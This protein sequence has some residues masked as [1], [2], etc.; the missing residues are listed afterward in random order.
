MFNQLWKYDLMT[1]LLSWVAGYIDTSVFF[2]L[3]GL[4]T[5][6][7]T[8]N[9]VVAGAELGNLGQIDV[10]VLVR[11]AVVPVF[12]SAIALVTV[13]TRWREVPLSHLLGLEAVFLLLFAIVGVANTHLIYPK[14]L[15]YGVFT[16]GSVGVFAMGIQNA[17]MREKLKGAAQTTIMTGNLTQLT[18]D[19]VQ[20]FLFY[21]TLE[22]REEVEQR[23]RQMSSA[24]LSFIVGAA[25]GAY[26]M[27]AI[28]FW[29]IVIAAAVIIFLALLQRLSRS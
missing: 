23:V 10:W 9:L 27:K 25:C 28:G 22:K 29:S 16:T 2:G 13:I 17:L 8:G 21:Q 6:H 15:P 3:N 24:L 7:V 26:F 1:I 18:I 12:I 20:T 5:A 19:L 4:F 11:L 14:P